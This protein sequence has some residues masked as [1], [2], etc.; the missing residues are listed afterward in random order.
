MRQATRWKVKKKTGM[1]NWVDSPLHWPGPPFLLAGWQRKP[2]PGDGQSDPPVGATTTTSTTSLTHL[3]PVWWHSTITTTNGNSTT[4]A[5][6]S[7]TCLP[8]SVWCHLWSTTQIVSFGIAQLTSGHPIYAH[9]PCTLPCSV[10][11][12]KL[13]K[14][15]LIQNSTTTC[16]STQLTQ[17]KEK[18]INTPLLLVDWSVIC[19]KLTDWLIIQCK[20][21]LHKCHPFEEPSLT[22]T[23]IVCSNCRASCILK[24]FLTET[25]KC[26]K[27]GFG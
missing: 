2:S 25:H 9:F 18:F 15:L 14:S 26:Y 13:R 16:S 27:N 24:D 17:S 6:A 1:I 3:T 11:W 7:I 10:N 23:G 21:N 5:P 19:H 22:L 8:D 4:N 12:R 20:P